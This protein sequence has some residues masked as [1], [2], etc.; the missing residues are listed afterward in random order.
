MFFGL[1]QQIHYYSFTDKIVL[2]GYSLQTK[3]SDLHEL[4]HAYDLTKYLNTFNTMGVKTVQDFQFISIS[5]LEQIGCSLIEIRKF[6]QM[7]KRRRSLPSIPQSQKI[8]RSNACSWGIDLYKALSDSKVKIPILKGLNTNAR[9]YNNK[10]MF[11]FSIDQYEHWAHSMYSMKN[12]MQFEHLMNELGFITTIFSNSQ[13]TYNLFRKLIMKELY[14]RSNQDDLIIFTFHGYGHTLDLGSKKN[15]FL[16]PWDAPPKDIVVPYDM[17][18][19]HDII[20]LCQYIE[21]KSI[22]FIFDCY[23]DGFADLTSYANTLDKDIILIN[24]GSCH[25]EGL[26]NTLFMSALMSAIS[27]MDI[28]HDAK[29]LYKSLKRKLGRYNGLPEPNVCYLAEANGIYLKNGSNGNTPRMSPNVYEFDVKDV[30]IA[31]RIGEGF[32]G[33][34]SKG[35]LQIQIGEQHISVPV[36]LKSMK[37]TNLTYSDIQDQIKE[38]ERQA[39]FRHPFIVKC[40][41][42]T[43]TP[44]EDNFIIIQEY[45]SLGN[46]KEFVKSET[47]SLG[48]KTVYGMVLARALYHLHDNMGVVHRDLAARNVCITVDIENRRIP[49]LI[50]FGLTRETSSTGY[51]N[52][53]VDT[54]GK[55]RKAIPMDRT[56]PECMIIDKRHATPRLKASYENDVWA[57]GMLLMELFSNGMEPYEMDPDINLVEFLKENTM[58]L[59]DCIPPNILSIIQ[60]TWTQAD[61]RL[62]P[63]EIIGLLHSCLPKNWTELRIQEWLCTIEG[64]ESLSELKEELTSGQVVWDYANEIDSLADFVEEPLRTKVQAHFRSLYT[65]YEVVD[66]YQDLISTIIN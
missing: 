61:R 20:Q 60:G 38:C 32:Y 41:G 66:N 56:A 9:S 35:S 24:S 48:E 19:M 37:T 8:S 23:F 27:E 58:T 1:P 4:L 29:G 21:S 53:T 47:L 63:P 50:D 42:W 44:S 57:F 26:D 31:E 5:D 34:V 25:T 62:K 46:M 18:S 45:M 28:S 55:L 40:F 39:A 13:V 54:T 59:P 36:A 52:V 65:E 16:V 2:N 6:D 22:M 51:Y 15:G 10:Y 49:K 14:K 11:S 43:R 33:V 12:A 7:K 30:Q 17:I 64:H 3:M